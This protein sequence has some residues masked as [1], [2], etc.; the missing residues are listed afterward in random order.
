MSQRVVTFSMFNMTDQKHMV[1]PS[2]NW[3]NCW[4]CSHSVI[5]ARTTSIEHPSTW[6]ESRFADVIVVTECGVCVVLLRGRQHLPRS[7]L[8]PHSPEEKKDIFE[9]V[10]IT[11]LWP[12]N[13]CWLPGVGPIDEYEVFLYIS[14][15]HSTR[16]QVWASIKSMICRWYWID[17]NNLPYR[18]TALP[19]SSVPTQ[20]L[21]LGYSIRHTSTRTYQRPTT[22][23]QNT[24]IFYT[25]PHELSLIFVQRQSSCGHP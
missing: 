16:L 11:D 13:R 6:H 18:I 12:N 19:G 9:T 1:S 5:A 22:N 7:T 23:D 8:L 20:L 10:V 3:D 14:T 4:L 2:M 15:V 24:P 17:N 21:T 25:V